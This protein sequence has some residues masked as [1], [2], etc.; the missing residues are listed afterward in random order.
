M[1]KAK[2]DLSDEATKILVNKLISDIV[3]QMQLSLQE[4][5][6]KSVFLVANQYIINTAVDMA[7]QSVKLHGIE[8]DKISNEKTFAHLCFWLIKLNPVSYVTSLPF[9]TI[10]QALASK[11]KEFDDVIAVEEEDDFDHI[12]VNTEMAYRLYINLYC[13]NHYDP[14]DA[15]VKIDKM[16]NAKHSEEVK[17]SLRFHNYSA[18][19]M[20]MFLETLM[21]ETLA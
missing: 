10:L 9:K 16:Y 13:L 17:R 7:S 18:R 8:S 20:A 4:E 21:M 1:T 15:L 12:P 5:T 3:C 2:F 19:A 6:S 14:E 11:F